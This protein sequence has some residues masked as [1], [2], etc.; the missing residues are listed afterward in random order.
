MPTAEAYDPVGDYERTLYELQTLFRDQAAHVA[1][2]EPGRRFLAVPLEPMVQLGAWDDDTRLTLAIGEYEANGHTYYDVC[3]D[4]INDDEDRTDTVE[5]TYTTNV[6]DREYEV[7]EHDD[8]EIYV[9]ED[10]RARIAAAIGWNIFES[11]YWVSDLDPSPQVQA[12]RRADAHTQEL[13]RQ[14]RRR[15]K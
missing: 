15:Q 8:E 2:L 13:L 7:P 14:W 5:Y 4:H 11:W 10:W 1:E 6:E 12:A 3:L 9:H